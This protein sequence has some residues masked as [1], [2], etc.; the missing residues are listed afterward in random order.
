MGKLKRALGLGSK[1]LR[2]LTVIV[3]AARA[4]AAGN[5]LRALAL[6]A[7]ALLAW[8]YMLVALAADL[9][10]SRVLSIGEESEEADEDGKG[11]VHD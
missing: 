8:K 4:F 10:V 7:V 6:G 3:A 2:A 11:K 9:I 1:R 5:R